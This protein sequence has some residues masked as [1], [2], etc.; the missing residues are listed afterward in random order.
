MKTLTISQ[1]DF[2]QGL[3][4][5]E[6]DTKAPLGSA[7]KMLNVI[8]SDR[9]GITTRPGTELLG[10]H[11]TSSSPIKGAFNFKKSQGSTEIPIKAYST[12]LEYYNA[13]AGWT[14]LK[15]GY[16]SEQEFGFTSSL[17]NTSNEDY[18]YF[19]N[20]TEEFSRWRGSVT[21]LNG[22]VSGGATTIT[23]DSVLKDNVYFSGTATSNTATTITLSTATWGTDMYKNFVVHIVGTGKIRRITANTSTVLTFDTL[24]SGPGNVAFEIRQ[25]AFPLYNIGVVA[26]AGTTTLTGTGTNFLTIFQ[27]GDSIYVDGE[28]VRTVLAVASNTSLTVTSAFSTT[29]SSLKYK[30]KTEI[31]YNDTTIEYT[32]IDTATTFTVGSAHAGTDNQAVTIVPQTFAVAP[33]GNRLENLLGRVYVG[34]VRSA[35]SR[36]SAGALQGSDQA[37]SLFVSKILNPSDFTFSATRAAGEGD[38]IN[39]PYGGGELTDIKGQ[40]STM[41][42]YKKG[43]IEAISYSQDANDFAVR[44]PLKTGKG[45]VGKV[46]KG[47]DDQYFM[48]IDKQYTSLGRVKLKDTTPQTENIGLPIKRLL[49][50]YDHTNFN[51]I[52]YNNRIFSCHKTSSD[53]TYNNVILV[54]NKQTKSFEGIWSLPAGYFFEYLNDLYYTESNGANVWKMLTGKSDVQSSTIKY[55]VTSDWRSNFFNVLPI[56][57]NT[58]GINSVFLEG[59]I[60]ANTSFTFSLYKDFSDEAVLSFTFGGSETDLVVG[61]ELNRFMGSTSLALEP[62]GTIDSPGSDGRRRFQFIV[63]FPYIYGETFSTGFS[64]SGKDQDWEIIRT[65]LGLKEDVSVKISN[66]KTI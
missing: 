4:L 49:D 9:G 61:D 42:A 64:S 3:H 1:S 50:A 59:Y 5:L 16:T 12:F 48:T 41:Y 45:S 44:V 58:Q 36:D 31:I 60:K 14:K 54:Y 17:V 35:V 40:E 8:I 51:G 25:L 52:E 7:R 23:V 66:I 65:S 47:T 13:T 43:Y 56:K 26:T 10:T 39:M 53:E 63:Y 24:G 19:C 32:N 15:T 2:K 34:N 22:N 11:N 38:I 37:G 57:N 62:L 33:R 55:P 29:A 18:C 27:P 28:T 30:G 6:D 20:R 46:I 21:L